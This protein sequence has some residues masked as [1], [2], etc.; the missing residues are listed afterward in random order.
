M[1]GRALVAGFNQHLGWHTGNF[2]QGAVLYKE[3]MW[4]CSAGQ[5]LS[6]RVRVTT[7]MRWSLSTLG[8][9]FSRPL[10]RVDSG[11]DCTIRPSLSGGSS[12][13]LLNRWSS[14]SFSSC[15]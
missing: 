2:A 5:Q 6:R 9:R 8:V 3:D 7:R 12:E 10:L 4:S 1:W 14:L 13:P 11:G 15:T